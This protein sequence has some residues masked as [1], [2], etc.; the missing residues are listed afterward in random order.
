[1]QVL[2]QRLY[3]SIISLTFLNTARERISSGSGF[4]MGG[5]LITNNHVI[6]V[7]SARHVILRTVGLDGSTTAF[8]ADYGHLNFKT[9]LKSGQE[10]SSWDYAIIALDDPLFA[11][12]PDLE[13]KEDDTVEIGSEAC[14]LGFQFEQTN[15]AIHRG[16]LSS[17]YF[18][19]GVRYIQI[20]GSVN[21]GNSGGPLINIAD[22][23]VIGLVTRKA[24]G[25]MKDFDD[26]DKVLQSNIEL[27]NKSSGGVVLISGIDPI[28]ATR[29]IQEQ[30]RIVARNIGR[31]ANVGIGYAYHISEVRSAL[32][33]LT[34][35]S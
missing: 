32:Q 21:N 17:S 24:T 12:I 19:A 13:A 3:P 30:I 29:A 26:L 22:G 7:P 31:S 35:S 18:K 4:K 27:L 11:Q 28:A 20:D 23:K 25:L 33:M 5:Y 10:A 6:Q 15:L 8:E 14:F 16:L 34:P 9:M 1:M 2:W